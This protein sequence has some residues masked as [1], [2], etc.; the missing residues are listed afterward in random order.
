MRIHFIGINGVSMGFLAEMLRRKGINVTGSDVKSGGHN[1]SNVI[2]A[3]AVVYSYAIGGDNPE[4]AEAVK[5]KIPLISRAQLLGEISKRYERIV[6]VSGTHGKTTTTAML[7]SMLQYLDP[8]VHVGGSIGGIYGRFGRD[9]LFITEACEYRE[10]FMS[11]EPDVS[12]ILN[13]E[14]DHAD[15]YK[16]YANFKDAFER[17]AQKSKVAFVCGDNEA[18]S[19]KGKEKTFTFGLNIE[20]D[21]HAVIEGETRG[22]YSFSAYYK[23][24]CFAKPKLGVRGLFNVTNAMGALAY[25]HYAGFDTSGIKNFKGVDRRF[26]SLGI[27][28]GT[29]YISDY[30]HHP[31]EIRCS[32]EAAKSIYSR[33]LTV[34]EPHTYS[35]TQAFYKDFAEA[36]ALSDEV[37]LLPVFAARED[38]ISG[39]SSKLIADEGGF[40]LA[41]SY[42]S[43]RQMI[44]ANKRFDGVIFM[45]AGTVDDFAR[46]FVKEIKITKAIN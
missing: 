44:N 41:D 39:V 33:V 12:I 31:H 13:V 21:Y 42:D 30:A 28:E 20:N 14:L 29:E 45:G 34:F 27:V 40:S 24:E 19:L 25:C 38:P 9:D 36:L 35:R 18:A 3:D 8:T 17:F 15:Y 10:S 7:M 32:L 4:Y 11:L 37:I 23:N 1:A 5:R 6:A 26:E 43:A 22:Y 46:K 2:G 16:T